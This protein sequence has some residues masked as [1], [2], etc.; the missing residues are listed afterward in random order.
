MANDFHANL[1][2]SK[3]LATGGKWGKHSATQS[4]RGGACGSVISLTAS[5][6]QQQQRRLRRGS[7]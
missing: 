4:Q 7:F 3:L 6:K 2:H 5:Q 1:A